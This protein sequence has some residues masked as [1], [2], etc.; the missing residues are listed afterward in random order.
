MKKIFFVLMTVLLI[1]I[2]SI[3]GRSQSLKGVQAILLHRWSSVSTAKLIET[4]KRYPGREIEVSFAPNVVAP[5]GDPY[6]NIRAIIDGLPDKKVYVAVYLNF[7]ASNRTVN[8]LD[9]FKAFFDAY[10]SRA[11][12]IVCPSLEDVTT[13]AEINAAARQIAVIVG[14]G[15]LS[16]LILRRSPDPNP[17]ARQPNDSLR[18]AQSVVISGR[19]YSY[20]AVELERHGV[21]ANAAGSTI[22]SNDGLF[23]YNPDMR[24]SDGIMETVNSF[25]SINTST[26]YSI[27]EFRNRSGAYRTNLW[28]PA[29]N[30]YRGCRG[31]YLS[32]AARTFSD[33]NNKAFDDEEAKTL[34]IFLGLQ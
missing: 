33:C 10:R 20:K 19:A 5:V 24:L 23:V 7:H 9:K 30:M 16:S 18:P 27:T 26:R 1:A 31:Y 11:Q 3:S 2:N 14:P 4:L 21:I 22:Y 13:V 25:S 15:N 29:Y 17:S 28:R 34:K 12:I 8:G 6:S 32:K